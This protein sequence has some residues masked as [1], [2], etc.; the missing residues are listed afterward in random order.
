VLKRPNVAIVAF[1]AVFTLFAVVAC[2]SESEP[3]VPKPTTTTDAAAPDSPDAPNAGEAPEPP[4]SG[5]D[6]ANGESK[7]TSLGCSG[8]HSTGTN[9]VVGPGLSGVGAKGDAYLRKSIT[10]PGSEIV[11]GFSNL[12]PTTFASLKSSDLDDLIAYLNTL[13]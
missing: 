5:G 8:C 2:S 11:D 9:K 1:L 6:A 7:F 3:S 12:M 10:D 4:T 13:N